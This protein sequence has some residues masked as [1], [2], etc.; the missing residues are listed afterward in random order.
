MYG[1]LHEFGCPGGCRQ[2]WPSDTATRSARWGQGTAGG[3][4]LVASEVV[5][6]RRTVHLLRDTMQRLGASSTT[7]QFFK[8][9]RILVDD[10]RQCRT[11]LRGIPDILQDLDDH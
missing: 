8:V 3:C 6:E 11:R 4:Q 2:A 5:V 9:V 1:P 7:A 10:V